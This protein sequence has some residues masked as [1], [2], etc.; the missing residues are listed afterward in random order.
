LVNESTRAD[1]RRKMFL[2]FRPMIASNR[3]QGLVSLYQRKYIPMVD[4]DSTVNANHGKL[5]LA[6]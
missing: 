2:A 1:P 3:S 5:V 4:E 6:D